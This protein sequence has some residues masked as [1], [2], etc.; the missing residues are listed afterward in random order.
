[1]GRDTTDTGES[2]P[3]VSVCLRRDGQ[4][5]LVSNVERSSCQE[6]RLDSERRRS[7]SLP[8]CG[9]ESC[10]APILG[11]TTISTAGRKAC[12]RPRKN[13]RNNRFMRLLSTALPNRR[14]VVMPRRDRRVRLG[15]VITKKCGPCS[16]FPRCCK[17]KN[18]RRESNRAAFGNVNDWAEGFTGV[19]AWGEL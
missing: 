12:W 2:T 4:I 6:A 13:S 1:M 16:F 9:S 7:S 18:S 5:Y 11:I 10:R 19:L 15:A 14:E 3:R 8:I 17:N